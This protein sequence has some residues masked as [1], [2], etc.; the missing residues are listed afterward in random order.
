MDDEEFRG[1]NRH[2]VRRLVGFQPQSEFMVR[3]SFW[4]RSSDCEAPVTEVDRFFDDAF[5]H[6]ERGIVSERPLSTHERWEEVQEE[7]YN[8]AQR[9]RKEYNADQQSYTLV[10]EVPASTSCQPVSH[11]QQQKEQEAHWLGYKGKY[12]NPEWVYRLHYEGKASAP[13][14][15]L[16]VC[17]LRPL[18]P[19]IDRRSSSLAQRSLREKDLH[20][21][22]Y[23]QISLGGWCEVSGLVTLGG[24]PEHLELFPKNEFAPRTLSANDRKKWRKAIL[25]PRGG[26]SKL[27]VVSDNS[28]LAWVTAFDLHYRSRQTGKWLRWPSSFQGNEDV[29][30]EREHDF[31]TTGCIVT[32]E[33]RIYPLSWHH[34][35]SMRVCVLGRQLCSDTRSIDQTRLCRGEE[36]QEGEG[37]IATVTYYLVPPQRVG[38]RSEGKATR[39]TRWLRD[40]KKNQG[41]DGGPA[42]SYNCL[43]REALDDLDDEV[44]DEVEEGEH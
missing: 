19:W 37:E 2:T 17:P 41:S 34:A 38:L 18:Q 22:G 16:A 15:L 9:V 40:V 10:F 42:T 20:T 26:A 31:Q 14:A 29:S 28:E 25:R 27:Y 11:T 32:K 6:P 5:A 21:K 13:N 3:R 35:R 8:S 23:F 7:L 4:T 39:G 12:Y 30:T 1:F 24:Y 36:K 33:V 43:L 44:E